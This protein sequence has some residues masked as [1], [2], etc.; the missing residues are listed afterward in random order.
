MMA[1]YGLKDE[2]ILSQVNVSPEIW[3]GIRQNKFLPSKNLILTLALV[4]Q[5]SYEDT[6]AMLSLC[7]E[8]FDYAIVKDVVIGYLLSRKVYNPAMVQAALEEYKVINLFFKE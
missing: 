1:K 2:E 6:K 3:K 4:V 8:E 7:E 5:M